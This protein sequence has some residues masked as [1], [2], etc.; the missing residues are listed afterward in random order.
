MS[1][2]ALI[3]DKAEDDTIAQA[4]QKIGAERLPS[5]G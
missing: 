2:Q 4:V 1:F 3:V 5:E